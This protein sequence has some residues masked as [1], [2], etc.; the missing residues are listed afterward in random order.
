MG[1][2]RIERK[3]VKEF[4][5][6]PMVQ[7]TIEAAQKANIFD[8]IYVSTDD[9]NL[10][11][12][13]VD[14]LYRK[15]YSDDNTTVQ[16]ACIKTLQQIKRDKKLEFD[17]VVQLLANCPLRNYM[18]IRLAYA[19]F[20]QNNLKFLISGS[21]YIQNPHWAFANNVALFPNSLEERSQDLP[22]LI[23]PNGA[24][25]IANIW[26]FRKTKTFYTPNTHIYPLLFEH[27]IDIDTMED[28]RRAEKLGG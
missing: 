25:W 2:K 13:G 1:S 24:I 9:K 26:A 19:Y 12:D 3:N 20:F 18:D 17:T 22:K 4:L 7:W 10:E 16:E 28:F 27:G 14:M 15:G 6:K 5:G 8:K 23:C 21:E 11:F